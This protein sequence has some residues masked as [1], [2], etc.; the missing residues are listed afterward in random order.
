MKR[1]FFAFSFFLMASNMQTVEK[2]STALY[3]LYKTRPG[4]FIR[5]ILCSSWLSSLTGWLA[6]RS[7][8]R[9]FIPT[10][11]KWYN[12]NIQ[13]A[14]KTVEEYETFN[15]FFIRELKEGVRK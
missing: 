10:F 5:K 7:I 4:Y 14:K 11:V 6:D 9:Y 15:Q 12:I 13:E 1:I 8:S 3:V 2:E